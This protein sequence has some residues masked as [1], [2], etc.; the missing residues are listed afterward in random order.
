MSTFLFLSK[1]VE[2]KFQVWQNQHIWKAGKITLLK[3]A[4]HVIP[5]FWMT[6]I[7]IPMEV[8]DRIE[9]SMN[10]FWW[11][12]GRANKGIRWMSWEKLCTVK[13]EGGLGV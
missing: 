9:K 8:C 1:Q 12:S 10:S 7:L 2:Q 13:E 4:A 6:M 3:K 11:E 5:N